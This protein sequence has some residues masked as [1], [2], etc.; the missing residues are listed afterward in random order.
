[1]M[2][3]RDT[4]NEIHAEVRARFSF[5]NTCPYHFARVESWQEPEFL[6][7]VI[8]GGADDFA[9]ACRKVC[10]RSGIDSRLVHC[11]DETGAEHC[12]LAVLGWVF[13][14]RCD[15]IIPAQSEPYAWLALSDYQPGG[16]WGWLNNGGDA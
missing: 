12:V 15:H 11:T 7:G 5:D 13:D 16:E 6:D 1:M 10:R 9:L 3:L 2:S 8:V 14:C 4:L